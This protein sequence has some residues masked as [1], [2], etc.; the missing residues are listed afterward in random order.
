MAIYS[1][2][3]QRAVDQV[4]HDVALPNLHVVFALDRAGAVGE[5]GET[6][7]GFWDI[8]LFKNLPNMTMMAPSDGVELQAFLGFALAQRGP[9]IL[10]FPKA[11]IECAEGADNEPIV[12][13]RGVFLRKHPRSSLLVCALGPVALNAARALD[14]LAAKGIHADLYSL[15]FVCPIDEA[16]LAGLCRGYS[17]IMTVEEGSIGGGVGESIVSILARRSL[18]AEATILGFD[19]TPPAQ[20]S[21][22]E[23]LREAGLD[24]DGLY[25]SIGKRAGENEAT[26]VYEA[27]PVAARL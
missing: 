25:D 5:D 15:R 18:K 13:G 6:H 14:R 10:R 19:A 12:M 1:T 16:Y 8:A 17:K 9:V 21:R 24:E 22:D 26:R 23:L 2:F 3:M 27:L 4:L 7:Q 11:R 20:A